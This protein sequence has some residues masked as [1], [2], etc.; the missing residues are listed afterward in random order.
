MAHSSK[1]KYPLHIISSFST[2]H[3]SRQY[4][5]LT[6]NLTVE[7]GQYSYHYTIV[8]NRRNNSYSLSPLDNYCWVC[9]GIQRRHIVV[10]VWPIQFVFDLRS[11]STLPSS[12]RGT[13]TRDYERSFHSQNYRGGKVDLGYVDLNALDLLPSDLQYPVV[14]KLIIS[15]KRN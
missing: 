4:P 11:P 12:Y 9:H 5:E 6:S 1:S 15:T 8:C 2:I 10:G 13:S 7:L 14:A 3:R